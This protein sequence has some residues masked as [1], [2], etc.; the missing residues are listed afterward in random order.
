MISISGIDGSGKTTQLIALINYYRTQG[1]HDIS[2]MALPKTEPITDIKAYYETLKLYDLVL[3]RSCCRRTKGAVLLKKISNSNVIDNEEMRKL[4]HYFIEDTRIWFEEV[5]GE[6]ADFEDRTMAMEALITLDDE[7]EG[8]LVLNNSF[9]SDSMPMATLSITVADGT[10]KCESG[11]FMAFP[12]Q[13]WGISISR[14]RELMSEIEDTI[15]L[16]PN[17]Y[18]FGHIYFPEETAEDV[19][20]D[21][22]TT[23]GTSA[24]RL[25]SRGSSLT[26][27]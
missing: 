2:Y 11:Y 20:A 10:M 8:T 21:V 7:G 24:I 25:C 27:C 4:S 16:H 3:I 18:E 22:K 14:D 23:G 1:F 12:L 15:I 9:Y 5:S 26:F 17:V 19:E 13:E 6:W